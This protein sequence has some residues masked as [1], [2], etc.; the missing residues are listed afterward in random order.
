MPFPEL[1]PLYAK[2]GLPGKQGVCYTKWVQQAKWVAVAF[3]RANFLNAK[4][5]L[6]TQKQFI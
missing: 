6:L 1:V 3:L 5:S 2:K 4:K